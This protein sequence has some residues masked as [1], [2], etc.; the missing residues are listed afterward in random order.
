MTMRLAVIST[1]KDTDRVL[2]AMQDQ[3]GGAIRVVLQF[4]EKTAQFRASSMS[5][6]KA[7]RG[8]EGHVME[9]SSYRGAAEVVFQSPDYFRQRD[10]FADH[11]TRNAS[12]FKQK[13]HPIETLDEYHSYF[14][15][16]YDTIAQQLRDRNVTHV[17]IFSVPH[18][19]YD[20]ALYYL[21][22]A[23]G[24]PV[25]IVTQ[26]LFPNQFFS[27]TDV[28]AMGLFPADPDAPPH[29]ITQ[30]EQPQ[31][32]YMKGVKQE[33]EAGGKITAA[34]LAEMM[35]FLV[36]K[37]RWRALNP[38][39]VW[40]L[41][42]RMRQVYGAFPRWR[43]PF[44]GFFHEHALSY[45]DQ[46]ASYEGQE[47]DLSG[48]YVYVPL[49][50][51]PE[52]TTS[53]LGGRFRD[54]AYMIERLAEMLPEGVR[55]LVKEN[56][57]QG[58]YMRGPMF[59]H[60]L[61]RIPKV[62]FLPSYANTHALTAHAQFV[63][64]IT[65][66]VGWEALCMGKPV[67]VF[68]GAWYRAFPGAVQWREGLRYQ[69]VAGKTFA[70][71]ALQQAVGAMLGRCHPGVVDRDYIEIVEGYSD[72]AN[73]QTVAKQLMGLLDGTIAP[74]FIAPSGIASNAETSPQHGTAARRGAAPHPT[75]VP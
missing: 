20:T 22:K 4:G 62:Q 55:I 45:F 52:M 54:Q 32:F 75:L 69:D 73:V 2:A 60:R 43:D 7:S 1:T 63:A 24:L 29:E 23:M 42:A 36:L 58:A 39:Y 31:L 68:G 12:M 66:T 14:H 18:L 26:S 44:A 71:D 25:L 67:L 46:L 57:K 15:V 30:G 11:L 56:P 49:Q 53:S 59:F 61:K 13:S 34:A 19:G 27:T 40:R 72:A 21:A 38:V 3:S 6:M 17:L 16:L 65:G 64:T 28:G 5:R 33:R 51:Q 35:T 8:A 70:H 48:K 47:I 74:S 41:L 50:M 10:E 37:G 9:G